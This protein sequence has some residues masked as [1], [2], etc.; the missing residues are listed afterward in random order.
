ML[1]RTLSAKLLGNKLASKGIN[2][3]GK[4]FIRADYRSK[5]SSVKDL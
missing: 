2:R 3:A 5:R 4:R 1:L